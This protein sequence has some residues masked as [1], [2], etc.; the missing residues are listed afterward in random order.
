[1]ETFRQSLLPEQ[2]FYRKQSLPPLTLSVSTL[3]RLRYKKA[4]KQI[5]RT[6]GGKVPVRLF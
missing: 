1:M 5:A 6:M 2:I 4:Y 3:K